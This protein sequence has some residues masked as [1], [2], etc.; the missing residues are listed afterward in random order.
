M[1]REYPYGLMRSSYDGT[2]APQRRRED[3]ASGGVAWEPVSMDLMIWDP[4]CWVPM[5][6]RHHGDFDNHRFRIR[7]DELPV[8]VEEFAQQFGFLS[9]LS[10]EFGESTHDRYADESVA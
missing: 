5:C 1:K 9:R 3:F 7:R 4:R 6:R 8:G 2:L 10:I